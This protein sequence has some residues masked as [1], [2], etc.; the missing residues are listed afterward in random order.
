ML[1][2]EYPT[3]LIILEL[4]QRENVFVEVLLE[5]LISEVDVKLLESVNLEVLKSEDI[6]HSNRG[7]GRFGGL[8]TCVY[9]FWRV[10][11]CYHTKFE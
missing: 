1:V 7:V 6:K 9:T 3:N 8:Y 5:L 10:A 2:F 4:F 11:I